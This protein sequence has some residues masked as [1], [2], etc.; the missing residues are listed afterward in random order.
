METAINHM[1]TYAKRITFEKRIEIISK[2]HKIQF[3]YYTTDH[4]QKAIECGTTDCFTIHPMNVSFRY[5]F[6]E[7]R[8]Q[9]YMDEKTGFVSRLYKGGKLKEIRCLDS[10]EEE[11]D[12]AIKSYALKRGF[13]S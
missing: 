3:Y 2:I 9:E 10:I 4:I 8:Y 6:V 1:V 5:N 12:E 11:L 13:V 7:Y